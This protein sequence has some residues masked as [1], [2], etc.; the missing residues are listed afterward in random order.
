MRQT[1]AQS[2]CRLVELKDGDRL[3][4]PRLED[5]I[6]DFHERLAECALLA[7]F[8]IAGDLVARN[9]RPCECAAEFVVDR[10][11]F[12]TSSFSFE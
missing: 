1:V 6:V 3:S 10:D 12:P 2:F 7:A 9:Q 11:L 8:R 5:R 4:G